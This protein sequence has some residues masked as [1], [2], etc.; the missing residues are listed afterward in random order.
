MINVSNEY[1]NSIQENRKFVMKATITL[2]DN[3]VL[4]VNDEDIFQG[5]MSFDEAVSGMGDFQVGSA[6]IGKHK[7]TLDNSDGKFDTVE[8]A[9]ARVVPFVGLEL[10]ETTEFIKKGIFTVDDYSFRGSVITL[11]CLDNLHKFERPFKGLGINFP[12]TIGSIL[13]TVATYCGVF[14]KSIN[15]YNHDYEVEDFPGESLSCL[16]VVAYIAQISGCFAKCDTDGRLEL[17]WYDTEAF[18]QADSLDGGAFDG[19]TT[20]K[21]YGLPEGTMESTGRNLISNLPDNWESGW[22]ISSDGKELASVSRTRYKG[23]IEIS[24]NQSYTLSVTHNAVQKVYAILH[25]YDMNDGWLSAVFVGN[26]DAQVGETVVISGISPTNA[27]KARVAVMCSADATSV[28]P[29]HLGSSLYVKLE[30]GNKPTDWTPAPEDV[31]PYLSGDNTDGGDFTYTETEHYDG[32]TFK[33]TEKYH[34][35]YFATTTPTV[36]IDDVVITGIKVENTTDEYSRMAGADGYVLSL[37]N[38]P[39]I[40]SSTQAQEV[41]DFVGQKIIGM[42]FRPF[43]ANVLSDPSVETGDACYISAR[44]GKGYSTY[45]SFVTSMSYTVSQNQNIGCEAQSPSRKNSTIYSAETKTVVKARRV[46]KKEISSYDLAIQQL[47]SLMTNSFGVF[48][49]EE[50]LEDGSVIYYMHDKPTLA[51]SQTI[52]KMTANT[53]TVSTNGGQ[54]W[55][56]GIDSSGN[57]VV[58][59][60]NAIGINAEWVRAGKLMSTNG[61]SYFDLSNNKIKT[62]NAE[63]TGGNI[64]ITTSDDYS[65]V[66]KLSSPNVYSIAA[67]GQFMVRNSEGL[68]SNIEGHAASFGSYSGGLKTNNV[69]IDCSNGLIQTKG[70]IRA[71]GSIFTDNN[72]Q[73][74]GSIITGEQIQSKRLTAGDSIYTNYML[75]ISGGNAYIDGSLSAETIIDRTP[76]YDGNALEELSRVKDDG[77]GGIDHS[78]LPKFAQIRINQEVSKPKSGTSEVMGMVV[79]ETLGEKR[80][81]NTQDVLDNSNATSMELQRE[82]KTKEVQQGVSFQK[83]IDGI[84]DIQN[85]QDLQETIVKE[86]E[87]RDIGAMVSVLTKAIQQLISKNEEQDALIEDQSSQ[88]KQLQEKLGG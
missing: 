18:E 4:E 56:A 38:N 67:P 64:N 86:V 75:S 63:I 88:I 2:E 5:G 51:E 1:K 39:L 46:A 80:V 8:F 9:N 50:I 34:H 83:S 70:Q 22:L 10:S 13:N 17:K 21:L 62:S 79:N 54:T 24:S 12:V 33:Q 26:V 30:K 32:G 35:F 65:N 42:R 48:K 11:E 29:S 61:E 43:S 16:D 84:D 78:T 7:L 37:E 45:Q 27:K 20:D 15:F 58:S 52:W 36:A 72:I 60:L 69:I 57:A 31:S 19:Q 44:T 81:V 87:G 74:T 47:T 49:S 66:I 40:Q 82:E 68:F 41:A 71:T 77:N 73:A 3:T 53:F 23:F 6:I 55:N 14:V 59:V 28:S 85:S 76:Y 25:F